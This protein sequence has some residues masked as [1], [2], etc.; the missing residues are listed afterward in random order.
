M[1]DSNLNIIKTPNEI[2]LTIGNKTQNISM[3]SKETGISQKTLMGRINGG[4]K[5]E[6][7]FIPPN[8]KLNKHSKFNKNYF[9]VIDDEHKAYW[10]GFLWSDGYLGHRIR[11]NGVEEYNLK[12]SLMENDYHHLEKFNKDLDGK[13]NIHFY[14]YSKNAF[15]TEQKEARLFITSKHMGKVLKY[16]YG[17][18]PYRKD[19]SKIENSVAQNLIKHLIR[20]IIDAD[21]T[22]AMYEI[23][24][25]GDLRKTYSIKICG[26]ESTLRYI[27]KH[28]I[29]M[30]LVNNFTRKLYKRH[31]EQ[32]RDNGCLNLA[33]AGKNNV[34]NILNYLYQDS[35]IYLDRKYKKYLN[36]IGGDD[37]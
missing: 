11:D 13:Y 26:T 30:N 15:K 3:W 4:W 10:L 35:T 16:Q 21:G 25:N 18:I 20:G 24:D 2:L 29:E 28:F 17:I 12:L 14:N 33:F 34:I 9:D 22:I 1:T 6:E 19:F 23:I 27:E 37:C 36:M 31:K 7:L 32:E 8:R 5:E